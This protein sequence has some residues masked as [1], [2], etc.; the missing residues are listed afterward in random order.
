MLK[1]LWHK[2]LYSGTSKHFDHLD[3]CKT[4]RFWSRSIGDILTGNYDCGYSF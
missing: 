2:L 1:Y 3:S 4:C